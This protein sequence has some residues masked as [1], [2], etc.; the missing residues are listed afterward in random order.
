M[1]RLP[2]SGRLGVLAIA[3]ATGLGGVASTGNAIAQA[4]NAAA[5]RGRVAGDV[6]ASAFDRTAT[7]GEINRWLVHDA[8]TRSAAVAKANAERIAA[9]RA[10]RGETASGGC[11]GT[12]MII[13]TADQLPLD[14]WM[15][16]GQRCADELTRV[17]GSRSDALAMTA[18]ILEVTLN[19]PTPPSWPEIWRTSLRGGLRASLWVAASQGDLAERTTAMQMLAN[20]HEGSGQPP[21]Q[22]FAEVA[23]AI[24]LYE[25]LDGPLAVQAAAR[26][27]AMQLLAGAGGPY[28][29]LAN[30]GSN[31]LGQH[32]DRV[33][34]LLRPYW[35]ADH[36]AP[37]FDWLQR[38]DALRL[39]ASGGA[40]STVLIPE[41]QSMLASDVRQVR[42]G[43]R[44]ALEA[45]GPHARDAVPDLVRQLENPARREE[46]LSVFFTLDRIGPAAAA[47]IPVVTQ[48]RED[49]DP[50]V[51]AKATDTLARIAGTRQSEPR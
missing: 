29:T 1:Q 31:R 7:L 22:D 25:S 20:W 9:E 37:R 26:R 30:P 35:Q 19:S 45:M 44:Q 36:T 32:A 27:A 50:D 15:R 6:I 40:S 21:A 33:I 38:F 23:M 13:I 46:R 18:T 8:R 47:A 16:L 49:E 39:A 17:S 43:A 12:L 5:Q 41:L 10:A 34:A 3:L 42:F 51:A 11:G 2:R 24:E 48:L 4:D 28:T 14:E